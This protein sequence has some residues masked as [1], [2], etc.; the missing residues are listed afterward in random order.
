MSWTTLTADNLKA[1][2]S[3]AELR[4]FRSAKD[5]L[6]D[7]QLLGTL[8][9]VTNYVRGFIKARGLTLGDAGTI[10]PEL[11]EPALDIAL[12]RYCNTVGGILID[13]KG[14]RADA[15]RQA[16][17]TLRDVARGIFAV[18]SPDADT[19]N[20]PHGVEHAT[21]TGHTPQSTNMDGLL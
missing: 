7:T 20:L 2:F 11:V 19:P 15:A 9:H 6:D 1:R 17:T 10:P 18:S 12:V 3:D 13:P 5:D 4:A 14:H 8:G 16:E 21:G